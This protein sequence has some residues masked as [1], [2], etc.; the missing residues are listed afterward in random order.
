MQLFKY[1][2]KR[3][4]NTDWEDFVAQRQTNRIGENAYKQHKAK[5]PLPYPIQPH[6]AFTRPT[7]Q[8]IVYCFHLW[9]ERTAA[10]MKSGMSAVS[11]TWW[12]QS[13]AIRLGWFIVYCWWFFKKRIS[14]THKCQR[15][16]NASELIPSVTWVS[17]D[18]MFFKSATIPHPKVY[19]EM[20]FSALQR[21][22]KLLYALSSESWY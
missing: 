19:T 2:F 10:V 22:E 21:N 15:K 6:L 11:S 9:T 18:F 8:V 17:S 14:L 20:S 7:K 12:W 3:D 5:P 13:R 4:A 16:C 1:G